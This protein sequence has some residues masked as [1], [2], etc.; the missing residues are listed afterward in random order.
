MHCNSL[1]MFHLQLLF[2]PGDQFQPKYR[3]ISWRRCARE[4]RR[5]DKMWPGKKSSSMIDDK[6]RK[7]NYCLPQ[8][9]QTWKTGRP[10]RN[11]GWGK[12]KDIVEDWRQ[13]LKRKQSSSVLTTWMTGR[14]ERSL[15]WGKG[16][17]IIVNDCRQN[18]KRK[19][20][21]SSVLTNVKDWTARVREEP[22]V[23]QKERYRQRLMTKSERKLFLSLD[24][25][26]RLDGQ[27]GTWG[28]A[29]RKISLSMI[30]D[31]I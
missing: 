5:E 14:P 30:V 23:G 29:K 15:G 13:N 18:I 11:L 24:K 2:S 7:G 3:V 19:Q 16:K 25:R 31:K 9:W 6:I 27:R 26:E 12:R 4:E 28:G 17:D 10:E 8:S 21:P 1:H 22:G 20:L